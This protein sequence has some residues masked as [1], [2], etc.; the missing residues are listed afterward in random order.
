MS[1]GYYLSPQQDWGPL[2]LAIALHLSL[3]S[4]SPAFP[5]LVSTKLDYELSERKII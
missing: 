4:C 3:K 5:T 1:K 2:Q